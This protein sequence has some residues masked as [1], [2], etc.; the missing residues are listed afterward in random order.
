VTNLRLYLEPTFTKPDTGEG[1]IRRVVTAQRKYLRQFDVEVTG[2]ILKADLT[3]GHGGARPL[4]PGVPFVSHSHGLYWSDYKWERGENNVNR[5]VIDTILCADAITVPSRWVR[6]AYVRG[7]LRDPKVIY[8]GVEPDEWQPVKEPGKY[9]LWNK[10]RHDAVSNSDDLMKIARAMPDVPFVSTLGN[11]LPNL[12]LT[13]RVPYQQMRDTIRGAGVYL[14]TARETFG[15]GTLEAL[16]CGVPVAG[17]N[18]GGQREIIV[19]GETGYLAEPGNYAELAECIRKCFAERVR[20]S[21]A[22]R[23]DV[24]RRWQW[25]DKI[26]QY[27]ALYRDVLEGRRATPKVSVIVTCHNLAK[28]LPDA[29]GSL[30]AQTFKDWECIIVD[31]ASTD[32]TED[33]YEGWGAKDSRF[34]GFTAKENLKLSRAR[35]AGFLFTQGQYVINLDADDRLTPNALALL[36]GALDANPH[37]H[38][39]YGSLDI[40]S[41]DGKSTQKNPFPRQFDYLEQ[42]AHL[43]QLHYAAMMRRE[44]WEQ[45]GGYRERMWRAEDAE[46]WCRATSYGF[47]ASKVTEETT[48]LWRFRADG[49]SATERKTYPDIDGDWTHDFPWAIAHTAKDGVEKKKANALGMPNLTTLPFGAPI[50]DAPIWHRE[51]PLVSIVIPLGPG[52]ER[53]VIDALDSCVAQTE[54]RW[55]AIVVND[56]GEEIARIPGAPYA[57]IVHTTD[58]HGAG[59]ARNVGLEFARAPLV[60][61]LD[62]DDFLAP[63]ALAAMLAEYAKGQAGYVYSGWRVIRPDKTEMEFPAQDYDRRAWLTGKATGRNT[64]TV[65]M[66]T[67]DARRIGFDAEMVGYEDWDFFCHCAVEGVC[68]AP[69][70]ELLLTYRHIAGQRSVKASE[71]H[72]ELVH[73]IKSRYADYAEGAKEMCA[74]CGGNKRA[75]A[76]IQAARE[77]T[78]RTMNMATV[79]TQPQAT[80][81]AQAPVPEGHTRMRFT[82]DRRGPVTYYVKGTPYTGANTD[83]WRFLNAKNEHVDALERMGVWARVRVAPVVVPAVAPAPMPTPTPVPIPPA[84]EQPASVEQAL[85]TTP[86]P[87]R[88]PPEHPPLAVASAPAAETATQT[89]APEVVRGTEYIPPKGKGRRAK[90]K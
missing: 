56:T 46:F 58:Q 44:V 74:C 62:A 30:E 80:A 61:F 50:Q 51:H 11:A 75:L 42:M 43:N 65:L 13:G 83:E 21:Q 88:V 84:P 57:R 49:K 18:Y 6:N 16:A 26:E 34:T 70:R 23:E 39:A 24:V 68:G 37:L 17:W 31:D 89:V 14:A 40:L 60:L 64:V 5:W 25:A 27:A 12:K 53:Y 20:L 52:H 59:R 1:G 22:A 36:V 15:I 4:R 71:H 7:M 35:N 28:Y 41:E 86:V 69:V 2:D 9:V 85:P 19:Q 33:I 67:E 81:P 73:T 10:P 54:H 78:N 66:A 47:R 48:L 3:A 32:N 38:I 63:N 8:H 90:R 77:A 45:V 29:L 82:G 87:E 79:G 72:T 76:E 55:E